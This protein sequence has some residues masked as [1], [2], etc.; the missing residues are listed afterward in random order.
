[1]TISTTSQA[2]GGRSALAGVRAS[3]LSKIYGSTA[4]LSNVDVDL[5]PGE[6]H[7][8]CGA[9]GS[10][11]STLVKILCGV[12][13]G[14]TGTVRVGERE[15]EVAD[16]DPKLAYQLGV[17]VVHQDLAIFADLSVAENMVIG[18]EFPV[19]R[20]GRIKRAE[21]HRRAAEAI[22][23]FEIR[24]EPDTIVGS[25]PVAGQTQVAIAR[26]LRDVESGGGLIIFDEPTAT[27]PAHEAAHLHRVIKRLADKGHAIL[28]ISHRLD[29]VMALTDRITVFRN[30]HV[31]SSKATADMTVSSLIGEIVGKS[32]QRARTREVREAGENLVLETSGLAAERLSGIDLRVRAGEVVGVAGLLG[33][34]RTELLR[35]LCGDLP[36]AEGTVA[37]DGKVRRFR[38]IDDAIAGGVVLVP[39]DRVKA[40]IFPELTLEE[41]LNMGV[42]EAYRRPHGLDGGRMRQDAERL[43]LEYR[44]KAPNTRVAINALSGGNQQKAILARWL[45][46]EPRLMLLD[47]PTQGVDIGARDDIYAAVRRV[48]DAGAGAL[49][50]T[51]DFEEMVEFVD[52]AVVLQGGRI[53]AEVPREELS[54]HHLNELVMKGWT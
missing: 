20:M 14:D 4:A 36:I 3:G 47:E 22:R 34:G 25:L 39:E 17:R 46:R 51:S 21:M 7:G 16:L 33:A 13:A 15:I 2:D 24:A 1:M 8:L 12:V 11:K 31:A 30:G 49:V 18:G 45:R 54:E 48:T 38:S 10:G 19:D 26:A 35:A 23:E 6:V 9:N 44:I 40:A 43:R 53:V 42:L 37:I 27:L 52:R 28:F 32:A 29:E 41:N 50:V 5:R